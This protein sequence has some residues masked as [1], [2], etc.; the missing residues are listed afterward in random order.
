MI[1]PKL[2]RVSRVGLGVVLLFATWV[3]TGCHSLPDVQPF[4][5]ATSKLRHTVAS[6]GDNAV[7]QLSGQATLNEGDTNAVQLAKDLRQNW[8]KRNQVMAALDDYAAALTGVVQA[9]NSGAD[10]AQAVGKAVGELANSLN[11]AFP[12][13]GTAASSVTQLASDLFAIAAREWAA[14]VLAERLKELDPVI[15]SVAAV[16]AI[17]LGNLESITW[18]ARMNALTQLASS[19]SDLARINDL[20][21]RRLQAS[22]DLLHTQSLDERLKLLQEIE[23]ALEMATKTPGYADYLK[24]IADVERAADEQ[25]AILEQAVLL[26]HAWAGAHHQMLLAVE[27]KRA[28]SLQELVQVANDLQEVYKQIHTKGARP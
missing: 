22:S 12:G 8:D 17:D 15:Q 1:S 3:L 7:N 16:L 20:K 24:G 14:H 6:T 28:P 18:A 27:Q 10:T 26:I 25:R 4:A 11:V 13:G 5:D 19:N 23:Q 2:A 21:R 9:G